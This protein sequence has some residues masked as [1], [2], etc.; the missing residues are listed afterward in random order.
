MAAHTVLQVQTAL[1]TNGYDPGPLDGL[2]GPLT[3]HAVLM[4]QSDQGLT[5]TGKI[6]SPT[7]DALFNPKPKGPTMADSTIISGAVATAED[8]FLNFISSKINWAAAVM[9]GVLVTFVSTHFGFTIPPDA[10]QWLTVEIASGFAVLIG[11]L[12]TFFNKPKVIAGTAVT[13][14][15]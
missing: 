8:Y 10:S 13:V 4:F 14:V 15:K 7:L 1:K 2:G 3:D 12:R 9:V 5:A 6:D 11:L